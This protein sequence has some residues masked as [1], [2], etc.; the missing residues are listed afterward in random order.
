[1]VE[2]REIEESETIGWWREFQKKV[3]EPKVDGPIDETIISIKEPV[4]CPCEQRLFPAFDV[5]AVKT[6]AEIEEIVINEPQ[7]PAI[8]P[9][10]VPL[11]KEVKTHQKQAPAPHTHRV[12][13]AYD[14]I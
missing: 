10:I 9:M 1:M 11:L 7:L 6:A 4:E 2:H 8:I 3:N 13:R 12:L 5:R 14:R